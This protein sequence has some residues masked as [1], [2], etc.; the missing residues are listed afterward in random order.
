MHACCPLVSD[1]EYSLLR[2]DSQT[3]GQTDERTLD[4]SITLT[5]GRGQRN[6]RRCSDFSY[7]FLNF[8]HFG[9]YGRLTL[10]PRAIPAVH[11]D[12]HT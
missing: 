6:S 4:R 11:T 12:I 1:D 10:P 7:F 5:Y 2:R 9:P 3:D 8:A